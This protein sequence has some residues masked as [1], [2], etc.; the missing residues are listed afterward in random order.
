VWALSLF[1]QLPWLAGEAI[2]PGPGAEAVQIAEDTGNVTGLV[3]ALRALGV[4]H[5]AQGRPAEAIALCQRALDEGRRN[6][7]GLFEEAPVL[8]LLARARL[9]EHDDAG[10]RAAADEA[11]ETARAQG[12][13]V[14]EAQVLLARGRVRRLTGMDAADVRP[15]LEAALAVIDGCGAHFFEPFVREELARLDGDAD[16]LAA[17]LAL[18]S[19]SGATGHV[20]RLS[21]ELAAAAEPPVAGGS[22][23]TSNRI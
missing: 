9:D 3:L 1:T 18:Y 15:D 4:A 5:L 12:A 2:E 21:A 6:R 20:R 14:T 23:V 7:S 22:A 16:A 13:K 8:A 11:V 17:V 19:A 10:A